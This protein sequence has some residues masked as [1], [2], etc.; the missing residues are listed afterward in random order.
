MA[1]SPKIPGAEPINDI[2]DVIAEETPAAEETCLVEEAPAEEAKTEPEKEP[3]PVRKVEKKQEYIPDELRVPIIPAVQY[4]RSLERERKIAEEVRKR[5]RRPMLFTLICCALLIVTAIVVNA[6]R[7]D[8]APVPT[9][10]PVQITP[11][12]PITPPVQQLPK[13]HSYE[14]VLEDVSWRDAREI[15]IEKG[16]YLAVIS[17]LAE[18]EKI[19]KMADEAGIKMLWVGCRR[20]DGELKW[21]NGEQVD[22]MPWAAGEPSYTDS[23]DGE[24]EDYILLWNNGSGWLLN[25]VRND[26]VG[27]YPQWYG[28]RIA[29]ICEFENR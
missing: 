15:C 9:A 23:L 12:A 16:G 3:A 25:D 10:P 13:E 24:A 29:Y 8:A 5:R 11:F 19:T 1:D 22:Y 18:Y 4:G 2:T 6:V 26:P 14:L 20:E 7:R 21:L 17:D 28:G 27:R